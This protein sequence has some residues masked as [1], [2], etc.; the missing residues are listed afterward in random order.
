MASNPHEDYGSD[1][2]S[3]EELHLFE[4]SLNRAVDHNYFLTIF[5][6]RFKNESDEIARF[7]EKTDIMALKEKLVKTLTLTTMANLEPERVSQHLKDLGKYHQ[8][9][10]VPKSLYTQWKDS[11][12]EVALLCDPEYSPQLEKI[13]Q[14]AINVAIRQLLQGYT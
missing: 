5:Y 7:F 2:L 11:L 4:E 9:L 3:F 8:G 13:W 14:K 12:I 1:F 10:S 6:V